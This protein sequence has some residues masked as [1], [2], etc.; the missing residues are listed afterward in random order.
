MGFNL[1]Q[2]HLPPC[3]RAIFYRASSRAESTSSRSGMRVM[4]ASAATW[5]RSPRPSGRSAPSESVLPCQSLPAWPRGYPASVYRPHRC[6]SLALPAAAAA[7]S[8]R[9]HGAFAIAGHA[10]QGHVLEI[11]PDAVVLQHVKDRIK[12]S[13][14]GDD[15][16]F[17]AAL[18]QR[19]QGLLHARRSSR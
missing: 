12:R 9:C 8:Q 14:I 3:R 2:E 18:P 1:V 5:D 19:F 4:T 10:G 16:Q 13:R 6:N 17:V 11:V 15:T 7:R